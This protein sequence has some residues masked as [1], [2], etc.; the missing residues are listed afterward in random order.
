[1]GLKVPDFLLTHIGVV[2]GRGKVNLSVIAFCHRLT[3]GPRAAD[4]RLGVGRD[5]T[6]ARVAQEP[7]R[8]DYPHRPVRPV[9]PRLTL[10]PAPPPAPMSEPPRTRRSRAR[11][12]TPARP[13]ATTALRTA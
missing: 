12:S 13:D 2:G 1:R 8:G 4:R 3:I 10:H 7:P 6:P 5:H 9:D 11:T